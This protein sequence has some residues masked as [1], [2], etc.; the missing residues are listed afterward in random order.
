MS[1]SMARTQFLHLAMS[2][3]TALSCKNSVVSVSEMNATRNR[4]NVAM[5][6]DTSHR[7]QAKVESYYR[8]SSTSRFG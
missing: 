4:R 8:G 7:M 1:T 2:A 6:D 5:K 3:V